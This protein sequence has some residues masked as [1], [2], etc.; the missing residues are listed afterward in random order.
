MSDDAERKQTEAELTDELAQVS[1]EPFLPVERAL[2]IGSLVLGALLLG[3]LWW[4]S[5]TQ[6]PA[7]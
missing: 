1:D 4:I 6:F 5:N 2:V 7:Q 3:L